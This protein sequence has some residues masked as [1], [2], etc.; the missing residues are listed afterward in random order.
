MYAGSDVGFRSSCHQVPPREYNCPLN[1]QQ[2]HPDDSIALPE[3]INTTTAVKCGQPVC[4]AY[5]D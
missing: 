3:A 1:A 4:Q 5:A 2:Q